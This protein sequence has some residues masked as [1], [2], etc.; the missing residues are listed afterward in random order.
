MPPIYPKRHRTMWQA[1]LIGWG[2]LAAPLSSV[3]AATASMP[4]A[5]QPT[6]Q[7]QQIDVVAGMAGHTAYRLFGQGAPVLIINGGPGLDSAG[8]EAVARQ[9]AMQGYQAVL[10]DQRG[11][12]GSSAIVP[13]AQTMRLDAMVDDIE[14]LRDHLH[15]A[16]WTILGHSF[17]GL[18]AGAY[19]VK[20]PQH[21]TALVMSSSAGVD[22]TF[23][24]GFEQRVSANLTA[25]QQ[26]QLAAY[27]SRIALGDSSTETRQAYA[28]VLAHAYVYD[29]TQAAKVA[30]RLAVVNMDINQWV[31][32]DL[33][34]QHF[35]ISKKFAN[36]HAPVLVLQGENDVLSVANAVRTQHAFPNA[37]LVQIPH[38]G[39]YGWLD[40][41][42]AY[43]G[44]LWPFLARLNNHH[45]EPRWSVE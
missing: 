40:Q 16:Q 17:G 37:E 5:A 10:Y 12:G 28:A 11:T 42:T 43:Y 22:L 19:A 36:F 13:S 32:A 44:A 9:I 4:S 23:R 45:A 6:A 18:L 39:H 31:H 15:L 33:T 29:K 24:D 8:F 26:L 38:C 25:Q 2:C 20:Y 7:L 30:A 35:D 41:P 34:A 27:R 14:L 1:L 3:H 21:V